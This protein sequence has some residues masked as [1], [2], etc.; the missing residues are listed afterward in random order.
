MKIKFNRWTDNLTIGHT[1]TNFSC[2]INEQEVTA[3]IEKHPL[4]GL[5]DLIDPHQTFASLATLLPAQPAI[6]KI[7][8]A[9][10]F[11]KLLINTKVISSFIGGSTGAKLVE[12]KIGRK[13]V[14]KTAGE[15]ATI[16]TEHLEREYATTQAYKALGSN[17]PDQ[18]LYRPT[19][20]QK[21]W[22]AMTGGASLVMLSAYIPGNTKELYAYINEYPSLQNERLEE[23]QTLVQKNF[24]AD[25]LLANWDVV[26]MNYDNI[27]IDVNTKKVWRVDNGSGLDYRAQGLKK[28][29]QFFNAT[30]IEFEG[31][32]N[33]QINPSAANIFG[34][35]TD[36]EIIRQ[37][38][39]I[40]PK[41]KAFLAAIPQDLKEVMEARFNYLI[42]YKNKLK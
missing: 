19:V 37:I 12:D 32:R 39:D 22:D 11:P 2:N 25:C 9:H 34:T 20:N 36:K 30:I 14:Q 17:V 29:P 21:E 1:D 5:G 28:E 42:E 6:Q 16:K 4:S 35:I 18:H 23:V 27:R 7:S 15:K 41:K 40:L 38:D 24:V 3:H 8:T 26:G 31:F 13:F 10:L 33:P